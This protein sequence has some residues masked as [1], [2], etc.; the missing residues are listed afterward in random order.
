MCK[1]RGRL[2][3][4]HIG[5]NTFAGGAESVFRDTIA[6]TQEIAGYAVF[7]ASCDTTFDSNHLLLDS[8]RSYGR[9]RG[10]LKYIFNL[11]NY[12]L[13]SAYL[14]EIKPDIIHTQN[15]MHLLSPSILLAL[16]NYKRQMPS[17]RLVIT[18]HNY[19]PC[20][21]NSC[22]NYSQDK[23]CT[24]CINTPSKLRV[25]KHNCD[26]RGRSYSF[27][28]MLR[29]F[30][31]LGFLHEGRIFDTHIAVSRFQEGIYKEA[32]FKN[33]RVVYNPINS[34][35]TK[36]HSAASSAK[37]L[38]DKQEVI[39]YFGRISEEK[40]LPLLL[41]A[42][43]KLR[44]IPRFSAYTL[45]VV[46]SPLE[47]ECKDLLARIKSSPSVIY[48]ERV[49][50][51]TLRTLLSTAKLSV[52]PSKWL[53]TFGLTILESALCG[54]VPLASEVGGLKE[55]LRLASGIGFTPKTLLPVLINTLDNYEQ[56]YDAF[57]FIGLRDRIAE[58]SYI[59]E[60]KNIY[61]G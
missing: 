40:N 23:I 32:G 7:T 20:P 54:V 24:L 37:M 42:F 34:A 18:Q 10:A 16:R 9:L 57:D 61:E 5:S 45:L 60:L 26:K 2:R 3:I 53:E 39:I 38:E 4:L 15:Y 19:S 36:T 56:I 35:F 52:L 46:G 21:N 25:F 47:D 30:F 12:H 49:D 33:M 51:A 44:Q 41:D 28:K 8:F 22:F 6:T 13:L 43:A 31:N 27:I 50:I 55:C 59:E 1:R 11:K 29:A 14:D 58:Y 48:H 17:S